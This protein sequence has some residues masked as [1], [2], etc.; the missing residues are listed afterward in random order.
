M[1]NMLCH[2]GSILH[3]VSLSLSILCTHIY[4]VCVCVY[5][6]VYIYIYKYTYILCL[7][8]ANPDKYMQILSN[9][10]MISLNIKYYQILC[11]Y[12]YMYN[13]IHITFI[14]NPRL[15]LPVTR[16]LLLHAAID[17]RKSARWIRLKIGHSKLPWFIIIIIYS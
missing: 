3:C 6:Y 11:I 16:P 14:G 8:H 13:Y 2:I 17:C 5:I 4:Y 9:T 10:Q 12:I 15:H 7:Y 1:G